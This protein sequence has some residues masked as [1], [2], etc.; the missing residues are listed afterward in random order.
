MELKSFTQGPLKLLI[1][2]HAT[3]AFL[4]SKLQYLKLKI[5]QSGLSPSSLAGPKD[6]SL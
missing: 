4:A 2:R 5:F 1:L 3:N 6:I